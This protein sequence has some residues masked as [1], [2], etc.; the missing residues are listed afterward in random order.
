MAA[1]RHSCRRTGSMDLFG[2]LTN[3]EASDSESNE[4]HDEVEAGVDPGRF[5]VGVK[6][7]G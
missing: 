5:N 7:L 1:A 3:D 2:A 4:E 6:S